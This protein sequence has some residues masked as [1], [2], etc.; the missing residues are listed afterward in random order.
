MDHETTPLVVNHNSGRETDTDNEPQQQQQQIDKQEQ[1]E[2]GLFAGLNEQGYLASLIYLE[3]DDS[4][5]LSN[6]SI[7]S[8]CGQS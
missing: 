5:S 1:K 2:L 4:Y 7:S 3:I 6:A 8:S